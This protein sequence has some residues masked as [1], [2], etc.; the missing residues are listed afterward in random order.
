MLQIL[1]ITAENRIAYEDIVAGELGSAISQSMAWG[2]MQQR[3]GRQSRGFAVVNEQREVLGSMLLTKHPEPAGRCFLYASRGPIFN[4]KEPEVFKLM[5]AEAAKLAKKERAIFLRLDPAL[6]ISQEPVLPGKPQGNYG[7]YAPPVAADYFLSFGLK[8]AHA[9]YQPNHSI[10]L[11]LALSEEELL[12]QMKPK[13]RYNIKLSQ[14]KGVTV[15]EAKEM[16]RDL[17]IFLDLLKTTSKRDSFQAHQGIYYKNMLET[18]RPLGLAHLL[19]AEQRGQPLAAIIMT[20]Y[21]NKAIYYYGASA[22]E[23]RELMAPYLLQWEAIRLAKQKGLRYYD[24]LGVAPQ[25]DRY[26]PWAGVTDFKRKFGGTQ[27]NFVGTFELVYDPLWYRM[28]IW[29]KRVRKL[30]QKLVPARALQ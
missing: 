5:L 18:L 11:D 28:M 25:Y 21:G 13:G 26:H 8:R 3:F 16:S 7:E 22:N 12:A 1:A 14:Q 15:R 10:V 6:I 29:G 2:V 17:P 24:F 19:I 23:K 30:S 9:S 20:V 27:L 4:P